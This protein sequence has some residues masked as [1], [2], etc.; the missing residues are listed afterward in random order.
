MLIDCAPELEFLSSSFHNEFVQIP[1]I[2]GARLAS[3]QV[4]GDLGSELGDPTA[5]RLK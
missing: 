1:N 2:A 5:D 3:P 4:A